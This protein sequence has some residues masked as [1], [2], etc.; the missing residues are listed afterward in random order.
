MALLRYGR[1]LRLAAQRRLPKKFGVFGGGTSNPA[2][3]VST[4][5]GCD[6]GGETCQ[7]KVP[8]S[9]SCMTGLRV[10]GVS[11]LLAI[12]VATLDRYMV[13]RMFCLSELVC[14]T[15]HTPATL[16]ATDAH[17]MSSAYNK[18][19]LWR[20]DTHML[21]CVL[22]FRAPA[23]IPSKPPGQS[24]RGVALTGM[25]VQLIQSPL[26]PLPIRATTHIRAHE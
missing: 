19:S 10:P 2:S 1:P 8:E 15:G 4:L 16:P 5:A 11:C 24:R 7:F 20:T 26:W 25:K 3:R 22:T 13:T 12:A 23:P 6:R 18:T 17:C 21:V 14:S 9:P